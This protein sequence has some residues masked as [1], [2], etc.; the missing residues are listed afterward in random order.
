[1]SLGGDYLDIFQADVQA[2]EPARLVAGLAQRGGRRREGQRQALEA[3]P[4]AADAEI[5]QR[6][7]KAISGVAARLSKPEAEQAARAAQLP[8][9]QIGLGVCRQPRIEDGG[10]VRPVKVQIGLSDG[11]QTEIV[12]GD[13]KEGAT[14]VIGEARANAAGGTSNPFAPKMFGGKKQ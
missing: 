12:G 1:M 13:L 14:V 3:A 11:I 6:V 9:R 8:A 10:Y 7:D 2:D 4:T 5:A